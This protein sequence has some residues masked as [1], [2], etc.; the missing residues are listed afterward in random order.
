MSMRK[1]TLLAAAAAL[2][3]ATSTPAL[4]L[5]RRVRVPAEATATINVVDPRAHFL[6]QGYDPATVEDL[7]VNFG[8]FGIEVLET[9][10]AGAPRSQPAAATDWFAGRRALTQIQASKPRVPLPLSASPAS[11][12][13]PPAAV[14]TPA[15]TGT[16]A[17][18]LLGDA[19]R[20]VGGF[21]LRF[22]EYLMHV[23]EDAEAQAPRAAGPSRQQLP[24]ERQGTNLQR[25]LQAAKDGEL[26]TLKSLIDAEGVRFELDVLFE[27]AR[28]PLTKASILYDSYA[29]DPNMTL[30]AREK[31]RE[32][33]LVSAKQQPIIAYIRKRMDDQD[34]MTDQNRS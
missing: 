16:T 22:A 30:F 14:A 17:Y 21:A 1:A 34:H 10:I 27:A 28:L 23:D 33:R 19:K 5:T 7:V 11:T 20:A 32:F 12:A 9:L 2:G 29:R 6:S 4:K 3:L 15:A 18:G 24:D 31:L 13:P 8:D 26:E 25:A